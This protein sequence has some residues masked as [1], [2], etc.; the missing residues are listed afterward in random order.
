MQKQN[1]EDLLIQL[2]NASLHFTNNNFP[3]STSIEEV[4]D[5]PIFLNLHTKL[6]FSFDNPCLYCIRP[7]NISNKFTIIRDLCRLD[8]KLGFPTTNHKRMYKRILDLISNDWKHLLRTETSQK[9][10]LNTYY[11]YNINGT[12]KVKDFQ[13]LSNKE[14]Y[15]TLQ[16]NST[17]YNKPIK[18]IL[19]PKFL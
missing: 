13:K 18:L 12:R 1:N 9:F 7:R 19:C 8:G 10:L 5:Q 17:K 2:L 15:F 11:Y 6:N 16:S 4:L 14:T 3:T